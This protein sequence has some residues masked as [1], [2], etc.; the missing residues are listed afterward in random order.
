MLTTKIRNIL[1]SIVTVCIIIGASIA[2]IAYGRG[3][4]LDVTGK[5]LSSTGLLVATSDPTGAQI[6]VDGK[7]KSATNATVNLRPGWYTVTIVKEGYQPWEK[8]IRVQGEVVSRADAYLF[9]S[10]PSLSAVTMSGV[11]TPEVA[12]DGSKLAYIVPVQRE[13]NNNYLTSRFG[14]WVLDLTDKPLGLNRDAR[15]IAKTLT[16]DWSKAKLAWSPD[17]KQLLVTLTNPATKLNSY[18]LLEADKLNDPPSAVTNIT[19][20]ARDWRD[21]KTTKDKEKLAGLKE[22][23]LAVATGSMK[24]V[25]FSPDETKILYEAT[26]SATITQIIKPPLIGTNP[27]AEVRT[28]K[29]GNIYVY[30]IKE[31]RNY[32]VG[33]MKNLPDL[34]WLPNS[35]HLLLVEK[36]KIEVMEFDATN[37]KT[38]YAGPFWDGFVVPWT[39]G[40]KLLILTNLNP[41]ASAINNLYAVNLR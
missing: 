33:E 18:Y 1:I 22:D 5:S 12:P 7:V 15:Q 41:S 19:S 20:L 11:T 31:D 29:P 13:N 30:D 24:I 25:N 9:P 10:N 14:I 32:L 38:V 17:S 40:T 26:N 6:I 37:R 8:R 34:Q 21:I 23:L 35:K 39:T 36:D 27:T 4:R 3:Y 16:L 28:L 2:V